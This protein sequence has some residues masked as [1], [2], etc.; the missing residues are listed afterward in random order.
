MSRNIKHVGQLINTQKRC[1]VVFREV[2]D[3]PENCL[4]VDTDSLADWMHDDVINAV[5][6]PG[7]QSSANFYEY[8]QRSVFTDGSNMLQTLHTRGMLHKTKT[9][10]VMMLPNS[11]VKIRLDELNQIIK[12]Q[13]GDANAIPD[14]DGQVQMAGKDI[15]PATMQAPASNADGVDD[16]DYAK[17]LLAQAKTFEAEAK[18]LKQE[19]Y[20]LVPSMKPGRKTPASESEE[21]AANA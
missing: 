5:E 6:S 10:N 16:T 18:R 2:P 8:A 1:V 17:T 21:T 7:A 3:E 19:A 14:S 13:N 15:E 20:D 11:G 4:V 9:E 12:E